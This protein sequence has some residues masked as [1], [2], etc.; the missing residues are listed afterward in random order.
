MEIALS[1]VLDV[2]ISFAIAT[3][4]EVRAL[5]SLLDADISTSAINGNLVRIVKAISSKTEIDNSVAVVTLNQLHAVK[6]Q[7][8]IDASKASIEFHLQKAIDT[9]ID[10]DKSVATLNPC[11]LRAVDTTL[12][13]DS[14]QTSL[15]LNAQHAVRTLVEGD[16]STATLKHLYLKNP[17]LPPEISQS[18]I[19]IRASKKIPL[20]NAQLI[21]G[22]FYSFDAIVTGDRL[23]GT[24]LIFTVRQLYGDKRPIVLQKSTIGTPGE[25]LDTSQGKGDIM[26]QSI[27]PT[28]SS[29]QGAVQEMIASILVTPDDWRYFSK[30]PGSYAYDLWSNDLMGTSCQLEVGTFS[31]VEGK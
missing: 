19:Q 29:G 14:S 16:R 17:P 31:I 30:V 24:C 27:T 12:D 20:K 13:I 26:I 2:D 5:H 28:L 25:F 15:K 18:G 7:L 10:A 21:S 4:N 6:S 22:S 3:L 23:Q 9:T 1:S 11:C 8:E